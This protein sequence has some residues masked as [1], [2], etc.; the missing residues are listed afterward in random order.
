MSNQYDVSPEQLKLIQEKTQRKLELRNK[1]LKL[2]SDPFI[3]A[4]GEG[5]HVFD[6]AVQRFVA[7]NVS[8]FEYFKPSGKNSLLGFLLVVAPMAATM[9]YLYT[10]RSAQ[11]E[12]YRKGE[13]AYKDR[14][15]KFC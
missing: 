3:H 2:K 11:E 6:P 1:F 5:G 12:K 14:R 9:T 15:F 8:G 4:T 7:L 13:V 10:S